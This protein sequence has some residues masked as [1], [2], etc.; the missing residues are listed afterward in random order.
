M[1][2]KLS[3]SASPARIRTGRARHLSGTH[4]VRP[5]TA[6]DAA[7]VHAL[8]SEFA[9]EGL[10]LRRAESEIE[11]ALRDFVVVAD[12]AG[13]VLGCGA[14][15]E[16][17]PS[18]AEVSAIAIRREAQGQGLG[19]MIVRAVEA[20]ARRRGIPELFAMSRAVR[21]FESLGYEETSLDRFPEKAARYVE[22]S[23]KGVAITPKSCLRRRVT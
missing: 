1:V 10:V 21:F 12:R 6:A 16:Y 5:A 7:D 22:L 14:L 2:H 3:R 20:L 19:S 11:H 23:A 4:V 18:V 9:D 8:L 17:S 13:T 15:T